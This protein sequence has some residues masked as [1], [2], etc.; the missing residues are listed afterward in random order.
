MIMMITPSTNKQQVNRILE[1]GKE[2][3]LNMKTK[4]RGQRY[5]NKMA[6]LCEWDGMKRVWSMTTQATKTLFNHS[7]Y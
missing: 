7:Y 5:I 1:E 3:S 6:K 2:L 4:N